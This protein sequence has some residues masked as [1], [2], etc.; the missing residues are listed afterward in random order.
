MAA[1]TTTS[2]TQPVEDSRAPGWLE[3]EVEVPN[4]QGIHARPATLVAKTAAGF[5][6]QVVLR[7]D[8][9]DINAKSTLAVLTLVAERGSRLRVRACGED[10]QEAVEAVAALVRR[11]FDEM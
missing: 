9:K 1:A 10:A 7:R 4:P 6:S 3:Q 2:Q 8:N 5:R 11:G